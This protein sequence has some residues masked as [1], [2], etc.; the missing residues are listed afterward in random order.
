[1]GGF[2][3]FSPTVRCFV[4]WLLPQQIRCKLIFLFLTL[5]NE[6]SR[7]NGNYI[8]NIDSSFKLAFDLV[9]CN[10]N[11][12]FRFWYLLSSTEYLQNLLS[13]ALHTYWNCCPWSSNKLV[14]QIKPHPNSCQFPFI[15]HLGLHTTI[16]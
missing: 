1:M 13:S 14:P 5:Q 3:L 4:A 16:T 8:L 9:V 10:T 7:L 6:C 15:N 2:L 12:V 11:L